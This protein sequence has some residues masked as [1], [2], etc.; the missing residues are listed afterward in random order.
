MYETEGI[1]GLVCQSPNE[2]ILFN[3]ENDLNKFMNLL[4]NNNF[5]SLNN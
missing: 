3:D 5:E 2:T 1:D 4:K